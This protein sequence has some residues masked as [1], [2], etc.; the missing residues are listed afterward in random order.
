M[1]ELRE[2]FR[3]QEEAREGAAHPLEGSLPLRSSPVRLLPLVVKRE[4]VT[5]CLA[6]LVHKA[7]LIF[8]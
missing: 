2:G 4:N 1:E 5:L 3:V 8:F 7:N 6:P